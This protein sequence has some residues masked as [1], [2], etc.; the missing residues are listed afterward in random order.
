MIDEG[1]IEAFAEQ[2]DLTMEI[3]ERRRSIGAKDRFYAIFK[4]CEV[5]KGHY[6][7]GSFGDGDTPE[8]AILQY[9]KNISGKVLVFNAWSKDRKEIAAW[10]FK[11]A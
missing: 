11:D 10:R 9:A 7:L 5:K 1:T 4:S 8:H 3:H 2:H 6:L